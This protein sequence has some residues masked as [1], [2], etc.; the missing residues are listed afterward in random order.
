VTVR[1]TRDLNVTDARHLVTEFH[2]EIALYD[3]CVIE[4]ELNAKIWC[5]D[6]LA[7]RL[8][9]ILAM[10]EISWHVATIDRFD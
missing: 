9:L 10:D 8:S 4:V 6:L 2:A 1:N 7:N 5:S 3:L